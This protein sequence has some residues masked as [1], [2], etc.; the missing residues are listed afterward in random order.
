MAD[1]AQTVVALAIVAALL[2]LG[3]GLIVVAYFIPG[4]A[5]VA[6]GGV[7]TI[8]GALATAL[9]APT[10]VAAALSHLTTTNPKETA[11]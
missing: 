11:P 5:N 10:G 6:W 3:L 2:V 4:A 7:G 1:Y 9:N 8:I